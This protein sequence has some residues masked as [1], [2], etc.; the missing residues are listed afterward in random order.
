M[1][2]QCKFLA[3]DALGDI[4]VCV[5]VCV[6]VCVCV[7]VGVGVCGETL[8]VWGDIVLGLRALG[9]GVENVMGL[10]VW[11]LGLWRML[12]GLRWLGLWRMLWGV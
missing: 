5:W 7:G 2:K 1:W 11:W 6:C 3:P 10:E 8:C 12:W 9:D 4:V